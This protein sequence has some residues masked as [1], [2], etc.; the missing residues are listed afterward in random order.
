V[1]G[2]QIVVARRND[3]G[4][5]LV[6]DPLPDDAQHGADIPVW[7]AAGLVPGQGIA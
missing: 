5:H 6:A 7:F 4:E 2:I 1:R 3:A